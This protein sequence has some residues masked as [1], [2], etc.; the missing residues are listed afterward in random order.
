MVSRLD[1]LL[2]VPYECTETEK[3]VVEVYLV[4]TLKEWFNSL[5]RTY[6]NDGRVC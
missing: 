3:R 4:K 5:F 6:R 1:A 2:Y